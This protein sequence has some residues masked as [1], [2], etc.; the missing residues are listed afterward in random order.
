M[1]SLEVQ[2]LAL[3]LTLTPTLTLIL[4][5]SQIY[6]AQ[7]YTFRYILRTYFGSLLLDSV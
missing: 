3:A 5:F 1:L 4:S 2:I 7:V 6:H